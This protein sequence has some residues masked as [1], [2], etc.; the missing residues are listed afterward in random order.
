MLLLLFN[1]NNKILHQ[2]DSHIKLHAYDW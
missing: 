1:F 2:W